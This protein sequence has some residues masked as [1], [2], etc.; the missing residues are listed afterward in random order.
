MQRVECQGVQITREDA[1]VTHE[2]PSPSVLDEY[3]EAAEKCI[4]E[5]ELDKNIGEYQS[6]ASDPEMTMMMDTDALDVPKDVADGR[7]PAAKNLM[8]DPEVQ[9]N[10]SLRITFCRRDFPCITTGYAS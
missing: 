10:L 1:H 4:N 8:V 2:C 6:Y 7:D 9:S 5:T 3:I